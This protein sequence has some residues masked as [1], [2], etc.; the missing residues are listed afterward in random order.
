MEAVNSS[1]SPPSLTPEAIVEQLRALRSQ[2]PDYQQI[3]VSKAHSLRTLAHIDPVFV[4]AA[5]NTIGA[6]SGV[7]SLIGSS[8]AEAQQDVT[9]DARWSAV[10]D[11][12]VGLLQGV[13]AMNLVRQ[14]R[15]GQMATQT[16]ALTKRLIRQ[17]Q[18]SAL[19]SYVQEMKRHN[20]LGRTR[21]KSAPPADPQPSPQPQPTP[22]PQSGPQPQ[23]QTVPKS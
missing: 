8:Q 20:R 22:Q 17:D 6:N 15:I 4:Q 2:M 21:A 1:G 3:P 14:H 9:D 16:Y 18:H 13:R 11:E 5:I 23:S 7:G 19:I 10:E 12:L